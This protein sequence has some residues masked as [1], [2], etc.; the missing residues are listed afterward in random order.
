VSEPEGG[1][2]YTKL[3]ELSGGP[4]KKAEEDTDDE[5]AAYKELYEAA[6]KVIKSQERKDYGDLGGDLQAIAKDTYNNAMENIVKSANCRQVGVVNVYTEAIVARME[7]GCKLKEVEENVEGVDTLLADLKGLPRVI[8]KMVMRPKSGLPW[9]LVRAQVFCKTMFQINQSARVIVKG[10]KVV[11]LSDRFKKPTPNGWSDVAI[12]LQIGPIVAEVQ[13]LHDK[14]RT[15]R[16]Q[17]GADEAYHEGRFA[18][19]FLAYVEKKLSISV[20]HSVAEE[21]IENQA[22]AENEEV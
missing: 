15:A 20:P 14:M 6:K 11:E 12:Y 21:I 8:E 16:Q 22:A 7:L 2:G 17:M 19:E 1:W 3:L 9:D 18:G 13:L 5:L 10:A 4:I